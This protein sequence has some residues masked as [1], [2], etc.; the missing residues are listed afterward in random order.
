MHVVAHWTVNAN[1]QANSGHRI[2]IKH[3]RWFGTRKKCL[4]SWAVPKCA[5]PT[6][7]H[8]QIDRTKQ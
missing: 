2:C 8:T 5:S 7:S 6:S 3:Y 4:M 1:Y